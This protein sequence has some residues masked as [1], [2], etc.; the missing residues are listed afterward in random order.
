VGNNHPEELLRVVTL[1]ENELGR[2]AVKDMLPMQPGDVMETFA[3]VDDLMRD[4]GFRPRTPIEQ[5][6]R[7]FVT[8]YREQYGI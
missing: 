6:I 3:D 4:T 8:W 7:R 2:A 5:G 1:L